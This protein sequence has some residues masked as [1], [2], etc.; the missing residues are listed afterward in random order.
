MPCDIIT[1]RTVSCKDA[2]GGILTVFISNYVV[3][4]GQFAGFTQ[5]A[6]VITA[7]GLVGDTYD[8]FKFE[9]RREMASFESA[10]NSSPEN[11]TTFFEQTLT[12]NLNKLSQQDADSLRLLAYGRPQIIIQD[13][14]DNLIVMGAENG[15]DVTGGTITTGQMFGDRNGLDMTFTAREELAFYTMTPPVSGGGAGTGPYPFTEF[16]YVVITANP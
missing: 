15:C 11:G 7:L 2:T 6:N 8:V 12:M 3:P 14:Q 5:T 9:L 4:I 10:V 16:P 13:N 1:G